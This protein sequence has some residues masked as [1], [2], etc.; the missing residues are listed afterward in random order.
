MAV[1]IT[2]PICQNELDGNDIDFCWNCGNPVNISSEEA[3]RIANSIAEIREEQNMTSHHAKP[4]ENQ[5]P[6]TWADSLSFFW[7]FL[8]RSVLLGFVCGLPMGAISAVF[9]YVT[10]HKTAPALEITLNILAACIAAVWAIKLIFSSKKGEF[11]VLR[12][13]P[14]HGAQPRSLRSLDAAR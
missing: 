7:S 6:L 12:R 4:D 3:A 9:E 2:C 1:I 8:W 11:I 14:Q 13:Y 10:K 5:N